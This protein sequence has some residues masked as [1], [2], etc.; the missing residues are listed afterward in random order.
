MGSYSPEEVEELK[1]R[2]D[3]SQRSIEHLWTDNDRLI[4]LLRIKATN[5]YF[6][7]VRVKELEKR[8]TEKTKTI[9]SLKRR[10]KKRDP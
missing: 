10:I 6:D 3:K 8:D 5:A 9:R 2:L 4:E 1:H 7:R